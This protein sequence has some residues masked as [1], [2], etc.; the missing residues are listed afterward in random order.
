M[1]SGWPFS[2]SL[3][4]ANTN[5]SDLTTPLLGGNASSESQQRENSYPSIRSSY[6]GVDLRQ[7]SIVNEP[8]ADSQIAIWSRTPSFVHF[9]KALSQEDKTLFHKKLSEFLE[10]VPSF[11]EPTVKTPSQ[12]SQ[13][14]E[15]YTFEI[16]DT[17]SD[18]KF[19]FKQSNYQTGV[20]KYI[21]PL[22]RECLVEG[23]LKSLEN[24]CVQEGK[25]AYCHELKGLYLV[26]GKITFGY[27]LE[28]D[29]HYAYIPE[30]KRVHLIEGKITDCGTEIQE[31]RWEYN[32]NSKKM[33]LVEDKSTFPDGR[34]EHRT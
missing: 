33:S 15:G 18:N 20:F 28:L 27:D 3:V 16:K 31:G 10:S 2:S 5:G 23:R 17:E 21:Q 26:T 25:W 1:E 19:I 29:G 9:F 6:A 22:R 24:D 8:R 7:L 12:P 4:R 34:V 13:L 14:N 32:S 11:D 30:M